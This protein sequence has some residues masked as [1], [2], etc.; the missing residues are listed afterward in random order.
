MAALRIRAAGVAACAALAAVAACGSS[1]DDGAT[2]SA[3]AP[4]ATAPG[5]PGAPGAATAPGAPSAAPGAAAGGLAQAR[6]AV[7]AAGRAVAHGRP[8]DVERDRLRGAPVWE[9]K[10][11]QGRARPWELDV[12]ADGRRVVRRHRR[13]HVDDDARKAAR[14][15]VPLA[16]ALRTAGRRAGGGRFDEAE[17]DRAR[18]RVVWEA[19]F[20][21]GG[22][23][24]VEVT[25]DARSGKVV[26]VRTD[27]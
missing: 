11:A 23:R 3:P 25:V 26:A 16:T 2:V 7:L 13:G 10:V 24:E 4:S 5:A 18:G 14:A 21:R 8:Y 20:E 1:D 6:R 15:T 22:G 17:I 27:D 12:S 19:T 9:V